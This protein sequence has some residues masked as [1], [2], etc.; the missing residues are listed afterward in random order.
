M[1]GDSQCVPD[2]AEGSNGVGVKWVVHSNYALSRIAVVHSRIAVYM[3]WES[4]CSRRI[5]KTFKFLITM[6]RCVYA[7][8][9]ALRANVKCCAK[10][11]T[12]LCA[13]DAIYGNARS[14]KGLG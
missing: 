3:K 11:E 10:D 14:I 6:Y 12:P 2:P 4:L 1:V 5:S 7:V 8:C 9:F 13:S